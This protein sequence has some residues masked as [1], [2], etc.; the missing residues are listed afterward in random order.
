M[1]EKQHQHPPSEASST[2]V[3]DA[4][5]EKVHT[6]FA[7]SK[8]D[9]P[10][11]AHAPLTRTTTGRS[12]RSVSARNAPDLSFPYLT[13]DPSEGV[14]GEYHA[15]T[16]RGYITAD[17]PEFGLRP[18][19]SAST[20][21]SVATEGFARVKS[22]LDDKK[23][24]TWTPGDKENPWEWSHARR[25]FYT[26]IV[27]AA[28]MEVALSSAIVTGDFGGQERHFHVSAEVMALTVTLPVCGF[29]IG[30]LLWS[31]LSELLGRRPLWIAPWFVYILFNI[32]CALAPNIGCLLVSRFLC[33]FFGSAPLT[34]AGGTIADLWNPEERGFAIA[35]FAAAPYTGPVLGP[36][37]GGFIGKYAGW[38]WL[39][40][41]NM[42][43]AGVVFIFICILPETFAPA[44]LKKRAA[45]MRAETGDES[46]VTEQEVARR[47]LGEIVT[48]TLVRPF[49]MLATEPILLLMS[50][51]ISLVYGLL[52]AYFFSFPVVFVEGYGWDDAKTGLTFCGVFIGVGLAL[53]TTPWLERK[54]KAA[55]PNPTPEDRLPGM[56]I[57]GPWV[58]ISLFIFGWTSPPY[59][60]PHGASWVG[61]TI[62]GIPFGYGMVLVYFAA[63]AF[64]I[65]CFPA[66]VAS[67]L[68]AKTV[69]RSA[70]GAVMP[71][72]IPQMFRRLGNGGAASLLAGIAIIMAM[73]PWA[74][75]RWGPAIR[76]R[77]KRAAA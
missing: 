40:W 55:G 2:T 63:N 32:P 46:F 38:R 13:S 77:S 30:P 37:I 68:A 58:P 49:Q 24:V 6:H 47:P 39:Y 59:V 27:A 33:G 22:R 36:L 23:L 41:V 29:G 42:I 50:L 26:A 18:I 12:I 54:Y 7:S 62:S 60:T 1:A 71:L 64:L 9:A 51:Y 35:I 28:V 66:Y 72:F 43:A 34:L 14:T 70:A 67:A 53:C 11:P 52:Y 44:L 57:G 48:E 65:E 15:E 16:E 21:H 25:W 75:V 56:L 8:A 73:V 3:A 17:D 10:A 45:K 4:P 61:P 31:P 74:F 20:R 76:A 5:L 69:V 19:L